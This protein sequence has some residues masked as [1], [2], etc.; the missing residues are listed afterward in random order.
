MLKQHAYAQAAIGGG[1]LNQCAR[2]WVTQ[3]GERVASY[4]RG[5][6]SDSEPND[7][8]GTDSE[9]RRAVSGG[10]AMTSPE[11][12]ARSTLSCGSGI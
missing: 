6:S 7:I 1:G 9:R 2:A 10:T 12:S 4:D 3:L 11:P 8:A 5:M